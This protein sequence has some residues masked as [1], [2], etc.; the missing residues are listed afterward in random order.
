LSYY[1]KV[2]D[3][4][5]RL[6][7]EGPDAVSPFELH[8]IFSAEKPTKNPAKTLTKTFNDLVIKEKILKHHPG[9]SRFTLQQIEPHLHDEL[10]RRIRASMDLI[11]LNREQAVEKTTQRLRGWMSSL[12]PVP[13]IR[14]NQTDDLPETAKKIIEPFRKLPYE[15]RRLNIDQN[16]KLVA[17]LNQIVAYDAGAIGAYWHSHWRQLN[18]NYRE[19]HKE[20]DKKFFLVKDSQAMQQGLIKKA[21]HEYIEDLEEQP[22][23][24]PMCRCYFEYVYRLNKVPEECLTEKGKEQKSVIRLSLG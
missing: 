19:D 22:A 2:K 10:E 7:K 16:A 9:V 24:A 12:S 21:G 18:Y 14:E 3:V 13:E 11:K 17:G 20:L 6:L 5:R 15:E 4:M 1:A 23:Q 8:S